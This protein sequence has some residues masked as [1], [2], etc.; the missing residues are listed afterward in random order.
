MA[1]TIT[2]IGGRA[3]AATRPGPRDWKAAASAAGPVMLGYLPVSFAFGVLAPTFGVPAWA[4]IAMS[5]VVFAG[6]SQFAALGPLQAGMSPVSIIFTTFLINLRHSLY[7]LSM[8]PEVKDWKQRQKLGFAWQLTDEAFAVHSAEFAK[9]TRP[10]G[11]CGK[12]NLL[13]HL[14]WAGSTALGTVAASL[15]PDSGALGLDF[16]QTAMFLALL[17]M[18]CSRRLELAVAALSGLLAVVLTTAGLPLWSVIAPTVIAASAGLLLE[19]RTEKNE[20]TKEA[21]EA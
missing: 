6:S 2:P 8:A 20:T 12:F 10:A 13:I 1:T 16:A 9:R 11:E 17:V 3:E 7:S 19:N 18:L 5:A 14:S 15:I 21:T 4:A